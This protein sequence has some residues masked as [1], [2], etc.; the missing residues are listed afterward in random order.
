MIK[1]HRI[2]SGALIFSVILKKKVYIPVNC[3]SCE[4]KSSA[5]KTLDASE[6]ENL[7]QNCVSVK[8]VKG[9]VIFKQ[10]IFSSNIIYLTKGVVKTHIVAD[11]KEQIIKFVKAPSYIGIPTTFEERINQYSATAISDAFLCII[12][13]DTFKNFIYNNGKF[14]YEIIIDLCKN[15]MDLFKQYVNKNQ[16]SIHGR[17]AETVLFFSNDI[18][19]CDK[20]IIPVS[21]VDLGNYIHTTRESISRIFSEFS[22]ENIIKLSGKKI[23]ILDKEKLEEISISSLK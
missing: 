6:L 15:E 8:F 20:F 5:A 23:S 21:R 11:D 16:K 1:L 3:K 7:E 12:N 18:F 19:G 10:G 13:I 9:D 2:E 14:T 17:L 22:E 4:I